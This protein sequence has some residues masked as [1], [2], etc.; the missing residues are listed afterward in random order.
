VNSDPRSVVVAA[1]DRLNAHDLDGYY[2]LCD[3]DFTYIGTTERRGKAQARAV[4]EPFFAGLADHWRR[5]AKLLVCG[6]TVAVWLTFGG[7]PVA[8]G[9]AF[10]AEF[11]DVIEVR[12]GRI[13]S[14]RIYADFPALMAKL[15]P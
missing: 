12:E 2:E 13:Q 11:C 7:T 14:L 10:E 9:R 1:F 8:T 4:D 15:A 5:L 3:N 6:D